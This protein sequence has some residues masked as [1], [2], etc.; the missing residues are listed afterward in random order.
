VQ[1]VKLA[2]TIAGR[3]GWLVDDLM[4][5]LRSHPALGETLVFFE[6]IDDAKLNGPRLFFS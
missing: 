3:K 5:R 6:E 1:G 4:E 2:L